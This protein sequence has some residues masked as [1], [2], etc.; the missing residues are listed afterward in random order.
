VLR[1]AATPAD[2]GAALG[3]D[4]VA[5]QELVDAGRARLLTARA[6]R[7]APLVD[8]KVLA[9]W[10]G[11]AISAFAR[12]GAAVA[13]PRYLR[14]A[15]E[16]ADFVLEHMWSGDRLLRVHA[17]GESGQTAFLE[18]YAYLTA[19]LLDLFEATG[20]LRWLEAARR[21]QAVLD[22]DFWDAETGGFF[23]SG[24]ERDSGLP[25]TKLADDG[26]IPSGNAIAAENLLRFAVL[27]D[28][29]S[30]RQR[31][32]ATVRA[33]GPA[34][35][36]NPTGAAR[37]LGVVEAMLDRPREVVLVEPGGESAEGAML[38]AAVQSQYLPNRAVVV[39]H[40]GEELETLSRAVAFVGE[41]SAIDG[42]P[43]A[44]VCERGRC[45]AP[46]SDP[47][48]LVRQLATV[49]AL[50]EEEKGD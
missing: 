50:P 17:A 8:A 30:A 38:R 35:A 2:V 49:A 1:V 43:T 31:A 37:L 18:D 45:L 24:P 13:E 5:A 46:T 28:D 39:A 23:D 4:P 36:T 34:L 29:E 33:V 22:R 7:P 26:A 15:R 25:R 16:A 42:R 3:I 11:L 41:K 6:T 10:N 14:V 19:G 21:M 32:A 48:V 44:Y 47:T 27:G 40:E 20:E 12:V 9:G